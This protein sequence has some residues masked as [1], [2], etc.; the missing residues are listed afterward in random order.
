MR[1]K[2]RIG[3]RWYRS[4]LARPP[5]TR[6]HASGVGIPNSIAFRWYRSSLARPPATR[7]HASGVGIL[8]SNRPPVVSLVPRSTTG[9]TLARLRRGDSDFQLLP[10]GI[11]RSS[12]DHRLHA[13]T[14]PAWGFQIRSLSGGIARSS[15]DHR[16]HA[17]TPPAWGFLFP[18]APRWYRSSLA[19]PPATR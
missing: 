17:A 7:W 10:G 8:I 5:A 4:S 11:A 14:P 9:Y 19:R 3:F 18:I 16:L 13:R 15:L 1:S 6:W 2:T 12:L